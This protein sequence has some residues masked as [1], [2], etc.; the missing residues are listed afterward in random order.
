MLITT[1][2]GRKNKD[3][4]Q[5]KKWVSTWS[6][7]QYVV[8][9]LLGVALF[10]RFYNLSGT[11][12]FLGDQGRDALIVSR[13][14]TA[15]DP[16]FI[17]PVTSVGNMYL[18]PLYYYFMLPF[19]WLTYPSPMGPV[20][21]IAGLGVATVFLLYYLG[22]ELVGSKVALL[23]AGLYTFS[24]TVTSLARFSWNPNPAPLVSLIMI[25]ALH[26]AFK[27]SV[28][29]WVVV[30]L[31]FAILIQLHYITLLSGAS[32]AVFWLY[33]LGTLLRGRT[34]AKQRKLKQFGMTSLVSAGVIVLSLLP[35]LLFDWKHSWLNVHAFSQLFVGN[36]TFKVATDQGNRFLRAVAESQGRAMHI[37]FEISIGAFRT[38]NELLLLVVAVVLANVVRT[39]KNRKNFL[40]ELIC[41]VFLL[42]GIM[43]TALYEH[44][45]FDHYI[46]YLFPITFLILAIVLHEVAKIRF[47]GPVLSLFFLVYFLQYNVPR[48]SFGDTGWTLQDMQRTSQAIS[49]RVQPGEKYNIVLLSESGDIDGQNY[50]YFLSTTENPP[51][52]TAER[53]SVE[54]LFI[55]NEDR[56]LDRVVDSPVYEIVVF[57]EKDPKEV[58]EIPGG[59]EIT[60]LRKSE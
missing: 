47:V 39:K 17:G 4:K 1:S 33:Q 19:L 27:K 59:P 45:I 29:Y 49:E 12:Q 55:I 30:S 23:A 40:G 8:I 51:V 25:W 56:V 21:A 5:I 16:V 37:L 36:D 14:F 3:M 54:T 22:K 46:A 32:F 26:R 7:Q 18:G 43:G 35:L 20:Y 57:P 38:L 15:R 41:I 60:V 34:A 28:W 24:A 58:F 9:A 6:W 2:F 13:I 50:R 42:V 11:V 31:C 53:G 44:S 10:T 48:M 52:L